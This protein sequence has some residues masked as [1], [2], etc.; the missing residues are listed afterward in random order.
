MITTA[1][2]TFKG[3]LERLIQ[4]LYAFTLICLDALRVCNQRIRI[5][6]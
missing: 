5:H 2:S 4:G 6:Y 1:F 3:S